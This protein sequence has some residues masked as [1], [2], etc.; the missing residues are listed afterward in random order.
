MAGLSASVER[1]AA[2]PN[3]RKRH[4]AAAVVGNTLEFY[5]FSTYA[6]FAAQ[7]GRTFFPSHSAFVSL[8]S[9]LIVF[10]AGFIGRPVGAVVIGRYGDRVGR[11]PAMMLSFGLMG[12]ALL[13]LVVTPSFAAIGI[14]APIIVLCLRLLQGFALGGDVGPTTAFL[15]EA[16]PPAHRGFYASL[17]YASQGMSAMLSGVVGF[18]LSQ[19]L[20]AAQLDSYGWRIAFLL[21]ALVLPVGLII[22]SSLPETLHHEEDAAESA[23]ASR[24]I[25]R[26]AVLGFAMLASATIAYYSLSFMTTYASQMLHMRTDVSFAATIFFGLSNVLFAPLGGWLSDRVG[27]KPV[28][29]G[30]RIVFAVVGI[31]AFMLLI[32]NRDAG[33]L[34]AVAFV[35]GALSQLASPQI[36]A[37]TEALPK[38]LRSA[39]LS[40]VYALAIM[41]FGGT[42]Q[43]MVTWL[44]HATGNLLMPAY[45]LTLGNIAGIV[46]MGMFKETAPIKRGQSRR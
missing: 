44:I 20:D 40:I 27:R 22:R 4:V 41:T 16:A 19:V 30:S 9:S 11:R 34:L 31:P 33:T 45:Y 3:I 12:V 23:E 32:R 46:S 2:L 25:A 17:Q 37:L 5:D 28:M 18:V 13:G 6:F 42:T 14:A 38:G 15:L 43:P 29:V 8:L 1:P 21:G 26:T 39:G 36:A 7:I 24:D 35:L 10:G